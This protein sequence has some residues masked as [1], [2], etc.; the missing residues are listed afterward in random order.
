MTVR[1]EECL[2]HGA[3]ATREGSGQIDSQG[4][5]GAGKAGALAVGSA[6]SQNYA[7][8]S[9]AWRTKP[10]YRALKRLMNS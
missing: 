1:A 8:S 6:R 7:A 4:L 2:L 3:L 9:A 10:R 5:A